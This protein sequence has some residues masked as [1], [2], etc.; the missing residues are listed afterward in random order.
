MFANYGDSTMFGSY[1][2]SEQ[3][4]SDMEGMVNS[5]ACCA[6]EIVTLDS[7]AAASFDYRTLSEIPQCYSIMMVHYIVQRRREGTS[8]W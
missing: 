4:T 1:L 7:D 5:A 6:C 2:P 8:L 3:M